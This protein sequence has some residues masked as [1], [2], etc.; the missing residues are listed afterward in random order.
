[1]SEHVKLF[2]EYPVSDSN[3][4]ETESL[5]T[6]PDGKGFKLDNIPFYVKGVS[7]GDVVSAEEVDGCLYMKELLEPSGHS[8]VRIWFASDQEVQ[9]VRETL[10]SM[11]CS[12]EVSDQPRLIAVDIPPTISYDEIRAYLDEGES[13]GKWDYEEA[14]LGFL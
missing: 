14:C 4:N 2:F 3:R 5:W 8:T 13:N 6:L 7:L 11:G 12:S 9:S 10:E 1:M